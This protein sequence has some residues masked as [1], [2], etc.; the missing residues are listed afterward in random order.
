ME[1]MG[2]VAGL[3]ASVQGFVSTLGAAV[4]ATVI[5]RSYDG[6]TL[7]L[8]LGTTACV[9]VGLACVLWAEQGRLFQARAPQARAPQ[10]G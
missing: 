1:P 6:S 8:A 7:P 4:F 5:G 9:A 2:E 10:A 3:A